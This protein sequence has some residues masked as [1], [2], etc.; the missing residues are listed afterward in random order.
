MFLEIVLFRS[1]WR[2]TKAEV[3]DGPKL[4]YESSKWLWLFGILFHYSFLVIVLRH[5]RLF[6]DPVPGFIQVARVW[7]QHPADRRADHVPD[8]C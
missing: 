4:T 5:M 7:G 3:H 1:L 8:R 6:L 2:N